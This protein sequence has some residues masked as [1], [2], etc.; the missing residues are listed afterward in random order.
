MLRRNR[1][2]RNRWATDVPMVV[3]VTP[4]GTGLARIQ[5][6]DPDTDDG[7]GAWVPYS[8]MLIRLT[9]LAEVRPLLPGPRDEEAAPQAPEVARRPRRTAPLC[10][11]VAAA[12][13]CH[14]QA[15][16]HSAPGRG[17]ERPLPLDLAPGRPHRT[18][19]YAGR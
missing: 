8:T 19:P 15:R 11:G 2:S 17:P 4:E 12:N 9:R 7:A 13:P 5:G 14:S 6:W 18:R 10:R 1:T 3:L 16:T